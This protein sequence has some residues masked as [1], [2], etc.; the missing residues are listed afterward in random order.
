VL[1][2]AGPKTDFLP[3]EIDALKAYLT[4]GGKLLVM[5]DPVLKADQ[6]QPTGLQALLKEWGIDADNDLVLDVSGMGRLLGT[7]ESV[8]VAAS[9]P[10]HPITETSTT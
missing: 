4:K 5:L 3:A 2:V 1:V 7:D 8:P 6:P 9:Y 10:S